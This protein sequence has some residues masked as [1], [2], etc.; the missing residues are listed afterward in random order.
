MDES[1]VLDV[2][3]YIKQRAEDKKQ[4]AEDKRRIAAL[5]KENQQYRNQ[6]EELKKRGY[7]L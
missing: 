7:S 6:L 1:L 4:I 2:D 3:I 5:E